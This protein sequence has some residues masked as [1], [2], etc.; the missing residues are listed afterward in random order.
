MPIVSGRA[1]KKWFQRSLHLKGPSSISKWRSVTL[2]SHTKHSY[3]VIRRIRLNDA[4]G[5]WMQRVSEAEVE[6]ASAQMLVRDWSDLTAAARKAR[7]G[8]TL[9]ISG[10]FWSQSRTQTFTHNHN[11]KSCDEEYASQ[12]RADSS[13]QT[14]PLRFSCILCFMDMQ[15]HWMIKQGMEDKRQRDDTFLSL[16]SES[17][18]AR[19]QELV[20]YYYYHLSI[21]TNTLSLAWLLTCVSCTSYP[22]KEA[23]HYTIAHI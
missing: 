8:Y 11:A 3:W 20:Y 17:K 4:D 1:E 12:K 13:D 21:N 22:A 10:H 2:D 23:Y 6:V 14:W 7:F 19:S 9:H 5:V 15:G 16:C 18:I